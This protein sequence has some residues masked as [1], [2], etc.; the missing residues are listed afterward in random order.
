[1]S[2]LFLQIVDSVYFKFKNIKQNCI[3]TQ[4][5]SFLIFTKTA[6]KFVYNY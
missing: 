2:P 1:M 4:F 5:I 6:P 3:I